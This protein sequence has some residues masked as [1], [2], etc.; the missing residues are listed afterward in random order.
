MIVQVNYRGSDAG[1]SGDFGV[2]KLSQDPPE[3][4]ALTTAEA[5]EIIKEL[6]NGYEP[7]YQSDKT[8]IDQ[9]REHLAAALASLEAR[10]KVVESMGG[11]CGGIEGDTRKTEV[12]VLW[13]NQ[14][15]ADNYKLICPTGILGNK[16]QVQRRLQYKV[17]VTDAA[18]YS[19]GLY[20][21]RIYNLEW[22]GTVTDGE[23]K[24]VDAPGLSW[25]GN[26][27]VVWGQSS[28]GTFFFDVEA[29][30]DI[31]DLSISGIVVGD[32][33]DYTAV[34]TAL[35]AGEPES[36]EINRPDAEKYQLGC[37]VGVSKG[38]C[39][40]K[41]THEIKHPCTG[42]TLDSWIEIVP[43]A[44]VDGAD[45]PDQ[46]RV[47][48]IGIGDPR[49]GESNCNKCDADAYEEICCQK[50]PVPV[51]VPV[52]M[53]YKSVNRGGLLPVGGMDALRQRY[54][55]D[56]QVFFIWPADGDCGI[57]TDKL[58]LPDT[59]CCPDSYVLITFV[60]NKAVISGAGIDSWEYFDI[61]DGG[62]VPANGQLTLKCGT[63]NVKLYNYG[64]GY[65]QRWRIDYQIV[66]AGQT[67]ANVR[68][69]GLSNPA[70][71][72]F[73]LVYEKNHVIS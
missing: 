26:G 7:D 32:S 43:T 66:I 3:K 69:E 34:V 41:I 18:A 63:L 44:C 1:S 25:D 33:R 53:E 60:D 56:V 22:I 57:H 71:G 45:P 6:H 70:V 20:A 4:Q 58:V 24:V 10:K 2:L 39:D 27:Q 72:T 16:R 5:A 40:Q 15:V 49:F 37:S 14:D 46:R 47:T 55:D 23:G 50:P 42:E 35:W 54:G 30:F 68:E 67:V 11:F 21:K 8:L 31:W 36:L 59:D 28:S 17:T 62:T 52:C 51:C 73:S 29:I 65:L 38:A 48:F 19:V 61:D 13:S 64:V 12:F 9:Q